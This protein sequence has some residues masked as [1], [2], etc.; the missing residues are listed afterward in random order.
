MV[1]ELEISKALHVLDDWVL[2]EAVSFS[3][4][5]RQACKLRG[6]EHET[7]DDMDV[8]PRQ[9]DAVGTHRLRDVDSKRVILIPTPSSDPNDPL[10][11]YVPRHADGKCR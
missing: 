1:E 8:Q 11:W 4:T 7:M 9:V 3:S 5:H 6:D 10:N 2:A